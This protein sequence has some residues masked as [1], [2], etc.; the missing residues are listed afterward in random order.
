MIHYTCDS[1]VLGLDCAPVDPRTGNKTLYN[2]SWI[3][4]RDSMIGNRNEDWVQREL[5][6]FRLGSDT[7]DDM[8]PPIPQAFQDCAGVDNRVNSAYGHILFSTDVTED[9][10]SLYEHLVRAF[11][12]EGLGTRHATAII[13]D[14]NIH[15]MYRADGRRDFICTNA[16]NV[17]VDSSNKLHINAQMRSMDA[18]W[19]YRAD[20]SMWDLLMDTLV[21]D[22]KRWDNDV[23]RGDIHFQVA[24]LH[25]YPRHFHLLEKEAEDAD[26]RQNRKLRRIW[27][28]SESQDTQNVEAYQPTLF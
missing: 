10:V 12:A 8:E 19:G 15:T 27:R 23:T 16:L 11:L 3:A 9:S 1:V 14:R 25:V 5:K 7:L 28:G 2:V 22:L 26:D 20:Y 21:E 13:S 18:V 17:M 24:N 6:W 4:D